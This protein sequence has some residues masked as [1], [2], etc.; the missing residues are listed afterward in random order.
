M[1]KKEPGL[2]YKVVDVNNI[3]KF[4]TT[5]SY[6]SIVSLVDRVQ[7]KTRRSAP[8]YSVTR[9]DDKVYVRKGSED[10]VAINNENSKIN[11][12]KDEAKGITG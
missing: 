11:K 6:D 8:D 1:K 3:V 2:Y 10:F 4:I 7:R 12:N 5:V 9:V